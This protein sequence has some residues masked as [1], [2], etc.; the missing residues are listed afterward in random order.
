M[1]ANCQVL[2]VQVGRT[3]EQFRR[4]GLRHQR[5]SGR[6]IKCARDTNPQQAGIDQDKRPLIVRKLRQPKRTKRENGLC[7]AYNPP[8]IMLVGD[9][10]SGQGK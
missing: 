2:L 7:D 8:S 6:I 5:G 3:G 10:P 4:Y 9:M 1:E